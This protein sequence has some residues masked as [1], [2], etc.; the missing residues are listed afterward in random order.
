MS[1]TDDF[2]EEVYNPSPR[3]KEWDVLLSVYWFHYIIIK[4]DLI[5]FILEIRS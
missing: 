3:E 4:D 2:K 5:I 1:E